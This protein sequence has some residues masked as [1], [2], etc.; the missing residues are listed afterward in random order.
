MAD[1][2]PPAG[3]T[4]SPA[5][6][7]GGTS[8]GTGRP[9]AAAKPGRRPIARTLPA[10]KPGPTIARAVPPSPRVAGEAQTGPAPAPRPAAARPAGGTSGKASASRIRKAH[11]TAARRLKAPEINLTAEEA[12]DV[13]DS[14]DFV[15]GKFGWTLSTD[16]IGWAFVLWTVFSLYVLRILDVLDRRNREHTNGARPAT[17]PAPR[18]SLQPHPQSSPVNASPATPRPAASPMPPEI[19]PPP[20]PGGVVTVTA[21]IDLNGGLAGGLAAVPQEE[22]AS[23]LG[24]PVPFTTLAERTDQI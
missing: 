16:T 9:A 11:E 4:G 12:D 7:A 2:K 1:D 17:G 19:K 13:A 8:K 18:P 24:L 10:A 6:G 23:G 20:Q 3:G 15:A 5:G 21:P 14:W 22:G